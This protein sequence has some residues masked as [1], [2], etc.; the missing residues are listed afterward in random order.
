MRLIQ[1]IP[2][3]EQKLNHGS[4]SL[5]NVGLAQRYFRQECKVREIPLSEKATVL[6]KLENLSTRQAEKVVAAISSSPLT[7]Q[8]EKIRSL[9]EELSEIKFIAD[10]ALLDKIEQLKGLLPI[11]CH[12]QLYL[13]F[14]TGFVI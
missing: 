11:N 3:L 1:E 10:Q 14:F 5:S 6:S 2:E 9:T 4:M 13:N 8:T 12:R 7:L